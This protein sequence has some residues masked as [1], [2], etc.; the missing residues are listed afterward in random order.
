MRIVGNPN[1]ADIQRSFFNELSDAVV[2][3][4]EACQ[5]MASA[6]AT[7]IVRTKLKDPPIAPR[8][9]VVGE[10]SSGKS[11]FLEKALK[12]LNVPKVTT[13]MAVATPEGYVGSN[14][15]LGLKAIF[16]NGT[17]AEVERARQSS[18]ICFEE[19]DKIFTRAER[20]G[21]ASQI[22]YSLLPL[23]ESDEVQLTNEDQGRVITF[24][25][26]NT[27]I[28]LNGVFS[29]IEAEAWQSI[30]SARRALNRFGF[31]REFVSRISHVI[32]LRPLNRREV[33]K[34]IEREV[35][36]ISALYQ[37]AGEHPTLP[38]RKISAIAGQVARSPFGFRTSRGYI[39]DALVEVAM[40]R[41]RGRA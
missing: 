34:L 40:Q 22:Q 24:S 8:I 19:V 35:K 4:K 13:S 17:K 37:I 9:L 20:D 31:C 30:E 15:T 6:L 41:R 7:Q 11:F 18:A 2:G 12:I 29:G 23:L 36:R 38:A 16:G 14:T 3:Q 33:Q 28:L 26:R 21:F 10:P 25:T 27:L 1:W 32:Y 5:R 39:H